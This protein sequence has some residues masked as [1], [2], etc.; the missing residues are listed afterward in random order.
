MLII[1]IIYGLCLILILNILQL[2]KLSVH[3]KVKT[4]DKQST[5][6]IKSFVKLLQTPD[7][8]IKSFLILEKILNMIKLYE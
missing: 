6:G 4:I 3:I 8:V 2:T 1:L 5:F 7:I